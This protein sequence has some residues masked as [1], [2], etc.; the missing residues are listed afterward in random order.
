MA[1]NS[2]IEWTGAT[3]NPLTGCTKVSPGCKHCLA[4]ETP[5][6]YADMKW[7]PIGEVKPGD[8]LVGF[9]EHL[10][11]GH[12]RAIRE[13]IVQKVWRSVQPTMRLRVGQREVITTAKHQ[14]LCEPR[15]WWRTTD[16]LR[17]GVRVR[18]FGS[19]TA[20][21]YDSADYMAGYVAGMT[22]GDGTFRFD[23]SWRSD[24]L[25]YPQMYW[26]VAV[27]DREIL[28]RLTG[29]LGATGVAVEVRPFHAGSGGRK[30]IWKL[31]TRAKT[32]LQTIAE[33]C[34]ERDTSDWRAGWLG[35]MFDAEGSHDRNLRISQKDV[36]V[37]ERGAEYAASFG[38]AT[39]IERW[40]G[41]IATLRIEGGTQEKASFFSVARPIL[42][43]KINDLFG[44]RLDAGLDEVTALERLGE[45][46][47]VDI[48]TATGTF[49]AAGICT[50]NCYAERMSLRLQAMG[51]PNY[52][53]GFALA[54]HE[55]MLSIP[56]HWKKPRRIFVNSMSDL[57][58]KNVP[59]DFIK[60]VFGVMKGASQHQ[61]Q[62]L[63]KR[64]DRL[65]ELDKNLDWRR[66]IWMGVSVENQK[67]AFRIDHL[68]Q[69][70]AHI[71]FLSL[72]PLL[73]PL[74]DLDLSG[75]DWVI[76][77]GES[78]PKARPVDP[79]WVR[80]IRDQC[81]EA[82]V[83]FFF[84]QWGG[85]RKNKTGRKLDGRIWSE[86]P[87]TRLQPAALS[88]AKTAFLRAEA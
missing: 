64:S 69:T 68:R 54:L 55:H 14:W 71:K 3:W 7:R 63:T 16:R 51:Q 35:G 85:K 15:P 80:D 79:A 32:K 42:Q 81:Q 36:T 13:A 62:V 9:D 86:Y 2:S 38:I 17:M 25:G 47:V 12:N 52:V 76:V 75:I 70:R 48:Q 87:D 4:P 67:Y 57:F 11:L 44:R 28:E 45:R 78:G 30:P 29:Y 53:N 34:R 39:K 74:S 82:G 20:N 1:T 84:K 31:E 18:V 50:H 66:N 49:I 21:D 83:A 40:N 5:V 73:G 61:F 59:L 65:L 24:K 27:T 33:L 58:Q 46:E 88:H 56:L 60:K 72:E 22:M 77:G 10:H 23:P 37:L 43:R 19:C 41:S 8:A 6:L 26:R